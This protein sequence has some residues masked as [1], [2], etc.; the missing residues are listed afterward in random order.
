[1][2]VT[3]R[4]PANGQDPLR[5]TDSPAREGPPPRWWWAL[6]PVVAIAV[7]RGLWAPD[8]PR[9]A[10][11]AREAFETGSLLVMHRCG[12]VYPDKPPLLFWSIGLVGWLCG[13]SEA[14]MRMVSIAAVAGTAALTAGFARRWWGAAEAAWAPLLLLGTALIAWMGGRIQID[15]LLMLLCVAA[16]FVAT[17]DARDA[18]AAARRSLLAGLF[19]GLAMLAKGP[20]ALVIVAGVLLAWR[21]LAPHASAARAGRASV[22]VACALALVPSVAWAGAASLAEPQLFRQLFYGQHMGRVVEGHAHPGPPWE[23]LLQ[24]PALLLPW[25]LPVVLGL[26][27]AWRA[28][29]GRRGGAVEAD[30]GLVRAGAWLLVL[31][32]F[33]SAIPTKRELYLLPAY[34]AAALLGARWLATALRAG[35]LPRGVGAFGVVFFGLLGAVLVVAGFAAHGRVEGLADVRWRAAAAGVPFL[36]AAWLAG[37][38]LRR[39]EAARWARVTAL[40]WALGLTATALALLPAVDALKS[41]RGLALEIA[42]LG[43]RPGRIPCYAVQP[44]GYRFYSGLPFVLGDLPRAREELAEARSLEGDQFLA[45]V[46]E[47]VWESLGAEGRAALACRVALRGTVGSRSVVVIA[48]ALAHER[49]G[50]ARSAGG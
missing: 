5:L 26:V 32:V 31:F 28:W 12:D 33:F 37:R 46:R 19:V 2:D 18:R 29:R 27:A 9:Y 17:S 22:M 23:H 20:V 3:P 34:P 6:L 16:L 21:F 11:V 13:W 1:M 43:P 42:A 47:D 45:M 14:A 4:R 30:A 49:E 35:R 25:T 48:A 50:E 8:E 7:T 15:P 41:P 24:L 44:E 39:G 38:A 10:Q 36:V 40:G